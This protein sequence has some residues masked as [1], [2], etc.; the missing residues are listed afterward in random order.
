M[1]IAA[2]AIRAAESV[3]PVDIGLEYLRGRGKCSLKCRM[4][5]YARVIILSLSGCGNRREPKR[6]QRRESHRQ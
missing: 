2:V 4:T 5:S 1:R 3:T 6:A